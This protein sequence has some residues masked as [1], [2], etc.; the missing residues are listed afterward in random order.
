[1]LSQR[2]KLVNRSKSTLHFVGMTLL[3]GA[4]GNIREVGLPLSQNICFLDYGSTLIGFPAS[5]DTLTNHKLNNSI[6]E[7]YQFLLYKQ[8]QL[9]KPFFQFTLL[10]YMLYNII[11]FTYHMNCEFCKYQIFFST[12]PY[13]MTALIHYF[14]GQCFF[15]CL[16][17]YGSLSSFS[18]SPAGSV[19]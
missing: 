14:S 19:G 6:S 2:K 1:M 13:F 11:F 16:F 10:T 5:F 18:E 3:N 8:T 9:I 17:F 7:L 4:M 12:I 15:F